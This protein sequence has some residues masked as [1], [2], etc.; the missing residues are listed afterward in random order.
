MKQDAILVNTARGDVV[1]EAALVAAL[2]SGRLAGAG[3]DVSRTSR[4][5]MKR[6]SSSTASCS[7][8]TLARRPT[9]RAAR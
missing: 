8:P 4:S 9:K 2:R 6:C 1:D 5:R 7:P 3:L